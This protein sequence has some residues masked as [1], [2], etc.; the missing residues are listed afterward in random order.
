MIAL[1]CGG[2]R[3]PAGPTAVLPSPHAVTKLKIGTVGELL[4][5]PYATLP[6]APVGPPSRGVP[7]KLTF[8]TAILPGPG[9]HNPPNPLTPVPPQQTKSPFA[10][11]RTPTN[12]PLPQNTSNPI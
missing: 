11:P 12:F 10:S 4:A 2:F 6:E 9:A 3:L 5:Q 7:L 8:A 1:H